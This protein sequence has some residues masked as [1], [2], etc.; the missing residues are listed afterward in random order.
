MLSITYTK[1]HIWSNSSAFELQKSEQF[2][3]K[4]CLLILTAN[5]NK[6]VLTF[7][8]MRNKTYEHSLCIF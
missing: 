5:L 2:M 4:W 6:F 1:N 3:A 7:I 8:Y